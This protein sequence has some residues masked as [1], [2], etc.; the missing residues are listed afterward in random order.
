MTLCLGDMNQVGSPVEILD[1]HPLRQKVA[2][3]DRIDLLLDGFGCRQRFLVLPHQHDAFDHVVFAVAADQPQPRLV[4]HHDLGNL[5]DV[6]RH[7][8]VSGHHHVVN[9]LDLLDLERIGVV[10]DGRIE[11]V[12]PLAQVSDGPHVMRLRP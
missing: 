4:P 11:R 9:V 7:V 1:P 8:V 10:G 2:L 12:D 6:Y 3:V 5:P